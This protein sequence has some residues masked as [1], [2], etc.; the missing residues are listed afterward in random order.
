MY[1]DKKGW[2]LGPIHVDVT[3]A[4]DADGER[5]DR[6]IRFAEDVTAEQRARMLEIAERTPVTRTLARAMTIHTTSS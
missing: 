3:V 6:A 4:R 1:A 5:A 2:T